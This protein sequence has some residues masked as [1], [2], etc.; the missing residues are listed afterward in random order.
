MSTEEDIHLAVTHGKTIY[1]ISLS[2]SCTV[3]DLKNELQTQSG[4]AV[5]LQKLLAKGSMLKD[6]QT[7]SNLGGKTKIMLMASA[8]ADI[9]KVAA[10]ALSSI[11]NPVTPA[12]LEIE[13][14]SEKTVCA[15]N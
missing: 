11:V 5:S 7:V 3:L 2:N 4:I 8:T 12:A 14:W 1:R 6:E 9:A 15:F 13:Y 10:G